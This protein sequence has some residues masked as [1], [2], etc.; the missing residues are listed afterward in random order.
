[1]APESIVTLPLKLELLPVRTSVPP[2]TATAS[3][4][5]PP[6]LPTAPVS[7]Q[8]PAPVLFK[9][10][11]LVTAPGIVSDDVAEALRVSGR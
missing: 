8:V 6:L 5:A 11:K 7:V 9:V 1:M 10:W 4:A 2:I 3:G